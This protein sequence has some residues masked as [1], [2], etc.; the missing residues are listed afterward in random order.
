MATTAFVDAERKTASLLEAGALRELDFGGGTPRARDGETG[1]WYP[2]AIGQI[3]RFGRFSYSFDADPQLGGSL[4]LS[5]YVGDDLNR[6][7]GAPS[8]VVAGGT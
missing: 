1:T 7:R 4:S 5:V 8:V 3:H 2:Q 6:P